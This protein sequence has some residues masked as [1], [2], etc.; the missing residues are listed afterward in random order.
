[1]ANRAQSSYY[2]GAL[3][4]VRNRLGPLGDDE[5]TRMAELLG[6]EVGTEGANQEL[7]ASYQLLRCSSKPPAPRARRSS[8]APGK[9]A[10]RVRVAL[11]DPRSGELHVASL[12]DEEPEEG[13][14]EL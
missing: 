4:L 7:E 10:E 8:G 6:G 11:P 9:P 12:S 14:I 5:A 2:L 13:V 1:M 3:D